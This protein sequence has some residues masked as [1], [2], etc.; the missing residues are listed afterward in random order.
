[1][2]ALPTPPAAPRPPAD[3]AAPTP[4]GAVV[5]TYAELA[6]EMALA[7]PRVIV[8]ADGTY[9]G[10]AITT[11]QGHRVWAQHRGAAVF[12]FG[13]GFRGNFG[14][15]GGALHGLVFDVD[16]VANVDATAILNEAIVNTWD[17]VAPVTIGSGLVV[18]DCVFD[19]HG[20]V[21]S[22]IQAASPGGLKV[23]RCE[24]RNLID[25]GVSAFRN[26]SGPNDFDP[27]ILEDIVVEN[28]ARPVPGS[29]GG[30]SA[31][32]AF[33]LGHTFELRRFRIRDCAWAGVGIVN[34]AN[35]WA[36][37]DGDIDR[38]GWGYFVGGGV[39]IYCEHSHDGDI[40]RCLLGPQMK[41][42]INGEWNSDNADPW[43]NS[44]VP[45]NYDIRIEDVRSQAYKVGIAFDLSV[46]DCTVR[47]CRIERAWMAGILDNNTFP[48]SNGDF[49]L[50]GRRTRSCRPTSSTSRLA[51]SA[52]KG[53]SPSSSTTTMAARCWPR[54]SRA[55][56]WIL[57]SSTSTPSSSL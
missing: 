27:I 32:L 3:Y 5:T 41:V 21:G 22:G 23:R 55:G 29:A 39:G 34:D 40:R 2:V 50:Q 1:M 16:D 48:D 7:G 13:I 54:R 8:V 24:F 6:A 56:R 25:V 30:V 49:P 31:E 12:E 28:V 18:E 47:R 38:V 45:R 9:S 33:F 46:A 20:V 53:V 35:G 19:G 57:S 36:V 44:L 26:G 43:L 4:T 42:G 17:A 14:I 52:S 15:A 10:A 37:E 11:N 51:P